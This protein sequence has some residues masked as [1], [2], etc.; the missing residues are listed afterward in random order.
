MKA[1]REA[2]HFVFLSRTVDDLALP[3]PS[4]DEITACG[5]WSADALPRP[6]SDFTRPSHRR[7]HCS[8]RSGAPNRDYSP[9]V[10][11]MNPSCNGVGLLKIAATR[12]A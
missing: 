3:R 9:P 12:S 5:Y 11:A 4:C 7:C 2:L 10:A 8:A 6:I 1:G